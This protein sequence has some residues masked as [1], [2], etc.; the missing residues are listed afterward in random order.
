[1]VDNFGV[2]YV[3][4]EHAQ[5]LVS[6]LEKHY[7]I[8]TDWEG[9]KY[10][11]LTLDWDYGKREVHLS[12]P[13]YIETACTEFGHKMPLKQQDSS[14]PHTPICYGSK[15]QCTKDKDDSPCLTKKESGLF[16][17]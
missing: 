16:S 9:K 11:G 1:M 15:V 6:V 17:E 10:I 2:K 8:S 5:H 7:K 3:G 14:H 12:M 13:G 4:E